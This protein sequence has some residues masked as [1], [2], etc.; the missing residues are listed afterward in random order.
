MQVK[1]NLDLDSYNRAENSFVPS[2]DTKPDE[3]EEGNWSWGQG[4]RLWVTQL[5]QQWQGWVFFSTWD[6]Q[7]LEA[8]EW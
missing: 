3:G 6:G 4:T 2:G 5:L 8:K 1:K 7:L